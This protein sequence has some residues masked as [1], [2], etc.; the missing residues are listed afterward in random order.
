MSRNRNQKCKFESSFCR[1]AAPHCDPRIVLLGVWLPI[2]KLGRKDCLSAHA[3]PR[4]IRLLGIIVPRIPRC[5]FRHICGPSVRPNQNRLEGFRHSAKL[6]RGTHEIFIS[7]DLCERVQVVLR[8]HHQ[9]RYGKQEIAF[10]GL[11]R[12]A[13]DNCAITAERKKGKYVYYRC[14]GYRGKC[15]TPRFTE[16][17]MAEEL[18]VVLK[19][20]HIPNATRA[21]LQES[22]S[23]DQD[24]GVDNATAQRN[25][26]EQRLAVVQRRM[27]QAY[28]D[29]LEGKIPQEFWERKMLEWTEDE[30]HIQAGLTRLEVP[31]SGRILDAKRI[32]RTRQQSLFSIPYAES[33]AT[34]RIA[35]N[36][37]FELL[38]RCSKRP[39]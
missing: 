26:L 12:C 16:S 11:L 20:I 35:Q 1:L 21:Q 29:K 38:Y 9:A 36:G 31:S 7:K 28:Q 15:A 8:G 37:A 19:N 23:R 27:D 39:T 34:S 30:R 17:E 2:R 10:R 33:R 32:F 4:K 14:T 25:S 5:G 24:Q 18:G 3:A 6:Y 22:L 13:H